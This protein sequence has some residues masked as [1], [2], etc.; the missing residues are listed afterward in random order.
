M[1]ILV[2]GGSGL[3]GKTLKTILPSAI[4]LNS[5]E[6]DLTD[7]LQTK[8]L[9]AKHEP[10]AVVHLAAY[11]AGMSNYASEKIEQIQDNVLMNSN[12]IKNC[13]E[14]KVKKFI[15]ILS[16]C[17]YP[18]TCNHYPMTE[19]DIHSGPPSYSFFE[20]AMSKRVMQV[21]IE[22]Y[23][24]YRGTNYNY[25]IPCNLYGEF[26]NFNTGAH[27]VTDFIREVIKAKK[28]NKKHITILGSGDT[29]R[30]FLYAL[31]LAKVIKHYLDNDIK[32]N[33]NVAYPINMTINDIADTILYGLGI[34]LEIVHDY[35]KPDGQFRKDISIEKLKS[36]MPN[37]Q[38][39]LL[40]EGAKI[41][42]DRICK[43]QFS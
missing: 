28:E 12:V 24:K 18:D 14:F 22:A 5:K 11:V 25:L 1:K 42:Y 43:E 3:V 21:E 10:D 2:T 20:Y 34:D 36:V 29:Y 23:N 26:D 15:A 27:F 37:F 16:S 33:V 40:Q 38:P 9:F 7:S 32:E 39:T 17:I 19:E 8:L 41:V 13:Y 31:D 35:S 4:Y 30:Q 6:A